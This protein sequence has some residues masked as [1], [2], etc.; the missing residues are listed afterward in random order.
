MKA[1][2]RDVVGKATGTS[3]KTYERAK[4]VVEAAKADPERF[5]RY[6]DAMDKTGKVNGAYK[7]MQRAK[8]INAKP[9]AEF[10]HEESSSSLEDFSMGDVKFPCIYADP[11]WQYGNQSTRAAT[12]NHYPTM[13]LSDICSLP[14]AKVAAE[15]AHLH[16]W[17]T[18]A[19]LFDAKKVIE[20]WGFEYK[21]VMVWVKPQMGIGNYWRVSHEFLL[22]ATRGRLPFQNRAQMSW[23][24]A[25]RT[26]HSSKPDLFRRKIELVSPAPRLELFARI[27]TPGWS[28]WGN[29]ISSTLYSGESS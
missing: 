11:P 12:D 16:L 13:S 24:Q 26:T 10:I 9:P 18:N 27:K 28:S 19:F 25:E 17:T 15:N 4:A 14:I 6:A 3:G 8:T 22:L 5:G 1:D 23:A 21:S 7:A 20:A 2:T 29:D